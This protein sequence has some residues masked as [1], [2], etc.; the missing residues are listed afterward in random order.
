MARSKGQGSITLRKDGVWMG[1]IT[2]NGIQKTFY[3]KDKKV[4]ESKL[5]EYSKLSEFKKECSIRFSQY[6]YQYLYTFK[7]GH[8]KDSSFDRLDSVYRNHI[9]NDS[10]GKIKM[11]DLNDIVVQEYINR[12]SQTDISYSSAKKIFEL[13]RTVLYYAYKKSDIQVD[14][15]SL[16][17]L[18]SVEKF[19]EVKHIETYSQSECQKLSN[20]ILSFK[21]NT[22]KEKRFLRYA[23]AFILMLHTGLRAGEL[24]ALEWNDIDFKENVI[25]VNKNVSLVRNRNGESGYSSIITSTK[26]INSRRTVPLNPPA[27]KALEELQVSY[28]YA[29]CYCRYVVCNLKGEFVKLRSFECKFEKICKVCGIKYKGVHA[30]RHTFASNLIESGVNPKV[31]STLLGHSNVVFT[32]N[33]YVHT[34]EQQKQEAVNKLS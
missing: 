9:E 11:C 12:K 31:V 8:I 5:F 1:R 30:L 21:T 6:I 18:P 25:N 16:I 4:V 17:S 2:K 10:I 20:Y 13:I 15:G 27:L 33:K 24:L 22:K 7:Y 3:N 23:P 14:Y 26:T 34:N 32:L 28:L 19:K 29:D